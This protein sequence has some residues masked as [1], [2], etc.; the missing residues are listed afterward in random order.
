[1]NYI[2]GK[3][4]C[5]E[6]AWHG[7]IADVPTAENPFDP[8]ERVTGCPNCNAVESMIECCEWEGCWR[9]TSCGTP[10]PDGYRRTCGDHIPKVQG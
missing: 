8:T 7:S 4:E 3:V 6:C 10:T 9:N 5:G 2:K 1:V